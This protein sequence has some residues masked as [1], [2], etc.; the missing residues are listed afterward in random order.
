MIRRSISSNMIFP[1]LNGG[2][3]LI[4]LDIQNGIEDNSFGIGIRSMRSSMNSQPMVFFPIP[5]GSEYFKSVQPGT[6]Q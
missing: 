3:N 5:E 6:I 1:D 4:P 2:K